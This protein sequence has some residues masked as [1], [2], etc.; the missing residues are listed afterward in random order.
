MRYDNYKS[1]GIEWLGDVPNHWS[2]QRI[3]NTI[4]KIGSGVTP[5]GGSEVY[6]FPY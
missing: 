5:K 6:V 4:I 3:K 1:S 2:V